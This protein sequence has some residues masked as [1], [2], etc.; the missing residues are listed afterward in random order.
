MLEKISPR[1]YWEWRG[2]LKA[3]NITIN[4]LL[5]N[6]RI[7][8]DETNKKDLKY[9]IT[10]IGCELKWPTTPLAKPK[11]KTIPFARSCLKI[12]N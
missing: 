11:R 10:D 12:V 8:A 7:E 4:A 9:R 3:G 1:G 2:N 6:G 5:Q